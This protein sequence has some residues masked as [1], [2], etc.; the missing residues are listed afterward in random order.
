[1]SQATRNSEKKGIKGFFKK[2]AIAGFV[3]LTALFGN[4]LLKNSDLHDL[5]NETFTRSENMIYDLQARGELDR[6]VFDEVNRVNEVVFALYND[7]FS[8]DFWNKVSDK[9]LTVVFSNANDG[10]TNVMLDATGD[11]LSLVI[12]PEL[13]HDQA[14]KLSKEVLNYY[15]ELDGNAG[16]YKFENGGFYFTPLYPD[17]HHDPLPELSV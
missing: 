15:Q 12:D 8:T 3:G 13:S 5:A 14:V 1:M 11:D 17:A 2:T 9:D 16:I 7:T 6:P 4:E 10:K